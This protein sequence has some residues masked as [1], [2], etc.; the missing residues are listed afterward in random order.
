[1]VDVVKRRVAHRA[2]NTRTYAVVR[3]Y[4]DGIKLK[5]GCVDCGYNAHPAALHFDHIDPL[6]KSFTIAAG[7]SRAKHLLEAEIAK[8]EVRCANCHAVR[9]VTEKHGGR[10]RPRIDEAAPPGSE[11]FALDFWNSGVVELGS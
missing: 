10:G 2:I 3:A 8:C 1:V 9:T 5:S 6:A 11:Q 4:L 7:W